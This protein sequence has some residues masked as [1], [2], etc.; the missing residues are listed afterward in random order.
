MHNH[1]TMPV[2]TMSPFAAAETSAS[3][4]QTLPLIQTA[5]E[6]VCSLFLCCIVCFVITGL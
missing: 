2:L 3:A 5:G 4:K 6:P 1:A